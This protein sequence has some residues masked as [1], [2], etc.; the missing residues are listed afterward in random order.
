[1]KIIEFVAQSQ[2]FVPH[3]HIPLQSGNNKQLREMRRRYKKEL[4]VE[5]VAKIKELMPHCCIGVDVI[6]GFPGE[7]NEDFLATYN[8]INELDITYL[9][10][11][12]YSER[13]NTPA[14]EMDNVVPVHIRRERNEM[15]RILSEKKKRHFYSQYAGQTRIALFEVSKNKDLMS[16]FTDNYLKI[17]LPYNPEMINELGQVRLGAIN[18]KGNFE[19]SLI[20]AIYV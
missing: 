13:P 6:V 18:E 8:F 16:G 20:K 5:R 15:L 17:E 9:H 3:F 10:V 4:Y 12:T 19:A 11:F 2:R 1:M 14:N 7:T